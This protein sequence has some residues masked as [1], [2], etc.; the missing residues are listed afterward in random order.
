METTT[1]TMAMA[2]YKRMIKSAKEFLCKNVMHGRNKRIQLEF[3]K[4]KM[5]CK[6]VTCDGYTLNVEEYGCI[7]IQE[8]FV[9]YVGADV[10]VG[11]SEEDYIYII[12]KELFLKS[13]SA[14]NNSK[15][16]TLTGIL[17]PLTNFARFQTRIKEAKLH[18]FKR[19][20]NILTI[21]Q[22]CQNTKNPSK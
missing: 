21:N 9:A 5:T 20:M 3:N 11:N 19:A 8:D 2:T 12:L 13:Y 6:A 18:T 15:A 14:T 1:A 4:E 10:P 17:T 7:S 22:H 16:K